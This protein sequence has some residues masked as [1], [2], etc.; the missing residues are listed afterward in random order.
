MRQLPRSRRS[1]PPS[2]LPAAA[3]ALCRAT[4]PCPWHAAALGQ[5]GAGEPGTLPAR[6]WSAHV[7]TFIG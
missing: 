5:A 2:G 1:L 4:P 7:F 6:A 3:R